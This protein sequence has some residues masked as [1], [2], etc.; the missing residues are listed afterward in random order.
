MMYQNLLD[1][2]D[3]LIFTQPWWEDNQREQ[4]VSTMDKLWRTMRPDEQERAVA[5]SFQL[6]EQRIGN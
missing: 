6:Y 3:T 2:Y 5:Y 1:Q 4:L